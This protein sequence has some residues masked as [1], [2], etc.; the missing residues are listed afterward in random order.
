MNG[1]AERKTPLFVTKTSF[2]KNIL[3]LAFPIIL[4]QLLRVS[5]DTLDS[6]MLGQIDQIQMSAVSQ[7]QQVFF[8]FYTV[9]NGFAVGCCV[10]ISQYWGKKELDSIRTLFAVGVRYIAVFA[11]VVAAVVMIWPEKVMRI[12]SSDP[13][14]IGLGASYLRIAAWM[15]VP[16]AISSMLFAC[17]RGIEQMKVSFT[18]NAISYPLNIILDYCFIFGAFGFP[19]LGIRGAACGAVMARLVELAVLCRFVFRK[20]RTIGLK[21]RDMLRRDRKLSMDF[22]KVGAPIVAHEMIWSTGTT[23]GS[24]ITGQMSTVIVTGYNV[25]NV[26]YQLLGCAMN[27]VL[28]ACSVTIGKTIGA[29]ESR[30]KIRQEAYSLVLIGL[31]GGTILGV[32][33]LILGSMFV[34]I[35]DLTP[36]AA[37]YARWFMVIFALIW[38]FSGMEMTGMIAA[39][40]AGGDGK[41]GFITDIFTMWLIT[42]P[43]AALSAFVLGLSPYVVISVIKFNIVL[44][45]LVGI[46]RIRSMKWVKNLTEV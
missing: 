23:A 21:P 7:A 16:C 33:T 27:G 46:W 9:C 32:L 14:L 35:Y 13:E 40:R 15:Y 39:L 3:I 26:M 30:E 36:D 28:H 22:L 8:V 34:G 42:I 41:T 45:A 43:L 20:E 29:G 24:S 37:E 18:T 5:V 11:A 1:A 44:E 12:Y 6:I 25:A 31:A 38:P 10:L 17:C 4:Q 2:Y 19:E